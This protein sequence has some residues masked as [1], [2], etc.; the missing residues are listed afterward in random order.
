M[1]R[2]VPLVVASGLA[3]AGCGGQPAPETPGATVVWA[4]GDGADGGP[5]GKAVAARIAADRPARLLYLGDVYEEGTAE[6][7]ESSYDS[8]YGELA[9]RTEP[10]PGNHEWPTRAEGYEP[11]WRRVKGRPIAPWYAS[12]A[13]GWRLLSLN[14]EAP[15]DAGSPQL[16][17]LEDELPLLA[18][19]CTIAFWH[20]PFVNAGKY[21]DQEDVAPLADAVRGHAAIV[22]AGHDHNMQRFRPRDGIVHYVS[23]AGGRE[24]YDVDA[25]DPRLAFSNDRDFGALRMELEP[26]RAELAFIAADGAV[27]DRSSVRCRR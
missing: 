24:R 19:T 11:Y 4:V 21:G 18:G 15:H 3:L 16:R 2:A 14:T 20:R 23:G 12:R 25:D 7:F 1:L 8:V 6:E 22:L 13:G 17:W 5:A 9:E 27:L 26:G 10:T